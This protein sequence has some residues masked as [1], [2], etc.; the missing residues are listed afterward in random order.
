MQRFLCC[1]CP[2]Q[3]ATA[4]LFTESPLPAP[5]GLPEANLSNPHT[6]EAY[7]GVAYSTC[8]QVFHYYG[9]CCCA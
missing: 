8:L 9:Q 2:S 4:T 7:F 5:P 1:K 3:K 6:R